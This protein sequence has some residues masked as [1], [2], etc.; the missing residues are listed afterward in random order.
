MISNIKIW[1]EGVEKG[2]WES[3]AGFL[4]STDKILH[5]LQPPPYKFHR[6]SSA[7]L[8]AIPLGVLIASLGQIA[9]EIVDLGHVLASVWPRSVHRKDSFGKPAPYA[10]G[11]QW[12]LPTKSWILGMSWIVFGNSVCTEKTALGSP[13]HTPWGLIGPTRPLRPYS[14]GP[15]IQRNIRAEAKPCCEY[16]N[17]VGVPSASAVVS[18]RRATPP[19]QP[20]RTQQDAAGHSRMREPQGS[21]ARATQGSDTGAT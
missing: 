6:V 5:L 7:H 17:K 21:H 18:R 1:G 9:H 10:L 8:L 11:S 16:D 3:V 20:L 15:G 14:V 4:P 13:L 19:E 2:P 12:H